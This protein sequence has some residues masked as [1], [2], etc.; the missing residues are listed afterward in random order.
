MN[1]RP[2][3][4]EM[5]GVAGTGKTTLREIL[6][7]RSRRF[8][9]RIPPSKLTY[10][11]FLARHTFL[12]LPIYLWKYRH[13][14]W[15]TWK[16]IKLMGYLETWIP[17]LRRQAL[18]KNTVVVL[19]P[20]SVYWLAA[21]REFG[22]EITRN[23]RYERWWK[24]MLRQWAAAVDVI[25]SL[26]AP[27]ELLFQRVLGRD[28]WHEAKDQTQ[29]EACEYFAGYRRAYRQIIAT[30]T[31]Q[32]GP[33]VIRFRTDQISSEEMADRVL[34]LLSVKEGQSRSEC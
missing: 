3:I 15:F 5:V 14:R 18:A 33:R 13:N 16:E 26:E 10:W 6:Y 22:P 20:G 4:I 9:F 30:M 19:D 24:N 25:I 11:Q 2:L 27:E 29:E 23:E 31:C 32:A 12:W 21:L 8:Q 7:Q 17:Y 34:A 28:E 1:N